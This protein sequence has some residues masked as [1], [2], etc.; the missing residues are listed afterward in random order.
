LTGEPC[1]HIMVAGDA[2][3]LVDTGCRRTLERVNRAE[4]EGIHIYLRET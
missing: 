4:H 1:R 2:F 3:N